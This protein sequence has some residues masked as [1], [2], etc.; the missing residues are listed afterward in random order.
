MGLLFELSFSLSASNQFSPQLSLTTLLLTLKNEI[1]DE[2]DDDGQ[3]YDHSRAKT[4]D[5]F[6]LHRRVNIFIIFHQ[7]G[8]LKYHRNVE[9]LDLYKLDHL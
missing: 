6:H 1:Q 3:D 2:N 9:S 5:I 4:K 7:S 8:K